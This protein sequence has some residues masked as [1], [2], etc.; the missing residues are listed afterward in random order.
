MAH[1]ASSSTITGSRTNVK[2]HD[3]LPF[4]EEL[5]AG[6]GG[7]TVA[8]GYAGDGVRQQFTQKERD[9]ETGLDYFLARYYG[10]TQGRFTSP[11]PI[12]ISDKQVENP[13]LW[14]LYS[15]VGNNPLAYTDPTGMELVQLGQHT[16]EQIKRRQAEIKQQ[17]KD[18][19]QN[20]S[21]SK[22]ERKAQEKALKAE[23]KTLGL[24]MEGNR[25]GN[26]LGKP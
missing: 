9:T 24:E 2:R 3:Y 22:N 4:G 25:I 19:T 8:H 7:R 10:S 6:T 20:K 21:I 13:P 26:A 17:L 15:C 1:R 16:D 18:L 23:N 11:D 12:I 5:F 14:N